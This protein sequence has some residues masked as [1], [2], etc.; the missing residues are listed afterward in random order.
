MWATHEISLPFAD[1]LAAIAYLSD[2]VHKLLSSNSVLQE[3][4]E[5][6]EMLVSSGFSDEHILWL[7]VV[8]VA[9][10][11]DQQKALPVLFSSW[12]PLEL[13]LLLPYITLSHYIC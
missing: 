12:N 9:L 8:G 1:F 7:V 6:T 10:S 5:H 3:F 4:S 11:H 2:Y 13:P